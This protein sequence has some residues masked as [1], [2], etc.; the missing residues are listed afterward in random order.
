MIKERLFT[1]KSPRLR[2]KGCGS[3]VPAEGALAE[4]MQSA[5][6]TAGLCSE[7]AA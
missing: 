1:A 3:P 5:L 4:A 6:P 7:A 2:R